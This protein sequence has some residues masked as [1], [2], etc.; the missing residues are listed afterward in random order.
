VKNVVGA[1]AALSVVGF[2]V[3]IMASGFG[4]DPHSVPF[5]MKGKPAPA[6]TIKRLDKEGQ[7]SLSDYAGQPIVLNFWATW[8]GPC[9]MEQPVLDWAAERYKGKAV[10]IGIVFEDTEQSTRA[11]LAQTGAAYPQVYDPKSTVAVDYAVAGVPETYFINRQGI[12]VKKYANPFSG[13]EEFAEQIAEIL[14]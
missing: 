3:Y 14:K 9:K 10:F 7:V 8:C 2:V 4:N 12:I 6:F 11:F 5:M 1:I 13:P